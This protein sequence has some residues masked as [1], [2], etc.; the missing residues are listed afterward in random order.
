M[1]DERIK[2]VHYLICIKCK[3]IFGVK[4]RSEAEAHICTGAYFMPEIQELTQFIHSTAREKGWWDE[5]RSFGD[6]I[7]LCH[8]E[9]S[10][11]LEDYRNGLATTAIYFTDD[12]RE[13]PYGIPVELA[14]VIIRILDASGYYGIDIERA[15]EVKVKYN[16]GRQYRHGG[17]QL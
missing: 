5:P 17:K 16:T 14:D 9:L 15:L 2:E 1:S 4:E 7:A 11:A 3:N 10:E 6:I 12:D 8:S 13:K